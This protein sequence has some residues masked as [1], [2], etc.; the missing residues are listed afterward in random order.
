M[1]YLAVALLALGVFALAA[2][3]S[4]DAAPPQATPTP[5][6]VVLP[7]PEQG[8]QYRMS[9]VCAHLQGQGYEVQGTLDYLVDAE[10]LSPLLE[11]LPALA[12]RP[13]ENYLSDGILL[14]IEIRS[15]CE[16][17]NK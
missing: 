15:L 11:S 4:Q 1:K 16:A 13:V 17:L 2:C 6:G 10:D 9:E 8:K 3:T 14:T 5:A 7:F 12:R